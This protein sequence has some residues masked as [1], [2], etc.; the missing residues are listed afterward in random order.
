[1]F[2][3]LPGDQSETVNIILNGQ[4]LQV[5]K[6]ITVAAVALSQKSDFPF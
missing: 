5:L 1:M 3:Q 6:G 2:K 4:P